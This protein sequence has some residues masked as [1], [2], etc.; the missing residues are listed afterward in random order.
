MG[1]MALQ[2]NMDAVGADMSEWLTVREIYFERTVKR[3]L[4]LSLDD[5]VMVTQWLV[6]DGMS[7]EEIIRQE[8]EQKCWFP[9]KVEQSAQKLNDLIFAINPAEIAMQIEGDNLKEWCKA[10][11]INM[12]MAMVQLPCWGEGEQE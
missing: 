3:M 9:P 1:I 12:R 10:M 6:E 5:A 4:M 2:I 7:D 11:Q 8:L